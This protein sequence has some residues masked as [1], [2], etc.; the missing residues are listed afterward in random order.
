MQEEIVEG[1]ECQ[2]KEGPL[3]YS[4]SRVVSDNRGH[5]A[6]S[7]SDHWTFLVQ[8]LTVAIRN[9]ALLNPSSKKRKWTLPQLH[10]NVVDEGM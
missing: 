1:Q 10:C 2:C 5:S 9:G 3:C 6:L 8:V 4:M 7:L